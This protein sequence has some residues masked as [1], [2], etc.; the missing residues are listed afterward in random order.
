MANPIP[1]SW[2]ETAYVV[3]SDGTTTMQIEALVDS[4]NIPRGDKEYENKPNLAGGRVEVKKPEEDSLIEFKGWFVGIGDTD[5]TAP[6]GLIALFHG[7]TDATTPF[8]VTNSRTRKLWTVMILYTD[9]T[10]ATIATSS[11]ASGANAKRFKA[12]NCRF[13]SLQEDFSDKELT[14]T[15]K[16]RCPAFTKSGTGNITEESV[17]GTASIA[18]LSV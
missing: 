17:D 11:I 1:D 4:I 9:D 2:S 5:D 3:V 8:T 16:F 15:F 12:A 14:A 10:A 6:D 18:A 7:G 13:V